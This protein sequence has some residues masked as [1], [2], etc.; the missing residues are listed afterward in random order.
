MHLYKIVFVV[1][2][3][4]REILQNSQAVFPYSGLC[5]SLSNDF[6]RMGMSCFFGARYF[7]HQLPL[8]GK[9]QLEHSAKYLFFCFTEEPYS[10]G[11]LQYL[12]C[13]LF[14]RTSGQC[15]CPIKACTSLLLRNV[16]S[17][18]GGHCLV[19]VWNFLTNPNR[20]VLKHIQIQMHVQWFIIHAWQA[21][22]VFLKDLPQKP[23]KKPKSS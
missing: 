16:M 2:N 8:C 23:Y 17:L 22:V 4:K 7:E 1:K 19:E 10:F 12:C 21:N 3:L 9:E 13:F 5:I 15:V 20:T 6:R 14:Q 11:C 18:D